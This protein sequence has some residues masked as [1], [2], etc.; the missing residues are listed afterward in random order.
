[1]AHERALLQHQDDGTEQTY[2]V[3]DGFSRFMN[4]DDLSD[5][6]EAAM[7]ESDAS[8]DDNAANDQSDNP[9]VART[10]APQTDGDTVPRWSNPDPYTSLPPPSE[11]TG[12]K[13]DVVQLIRKAKNQVAQEKADSKNEVAANDDFIS[14]GNDLSEEDDEADDDDDDNSVDGLANGRASPRTLQGSMNDIGFDH[15]ATYDSYEPPPR[16]PRNTHEIY[17]PTAGG[18][19][20]KRKG[21]GGVVGIVPDWQ[22]TS[23]SSPT[24]WATRHQ[25]EHLVNMSERW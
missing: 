3:S 17:P 18:K 7:D 12:V 4:I 16:R 20:K 21:D 19:G 25:Y 22:P 6:E 11:T 13:R 15:R 14:L 5:D 8:G 24:P 1:M 10:R 23:R 2:G 9:K